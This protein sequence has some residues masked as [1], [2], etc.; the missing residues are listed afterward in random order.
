VRIFDSKFKIIIIIGVGFLCFFTLGMLLAKKTSVER[1]YKVKIDD[2]I[3][4]E[5][6]KLQWPN[7][8]QYVN[9]VMGATSAT[10]ICG[11]SLSKSVIEKLND[12]KNSQAGLTFGVACHELWVLFPENDLKIWKT[13]SYQEKAI[14]AHE[15]FHLAVQMYSKRRARMENAMDYNY[16][17]QLHAAKKYETNEF[18]QKISDISKEKSNNAKTHCDSLFGIRE[19]YNELQIDY[20]R[21]QIGMEWPAEFYMREV[22][23]ADN[24][25]E[26]AAFR[27][28]IGKNSPEFIPYNANI[29]YSAGTEAIKKIEQTVPRKDWQNRYLQGET[30]LNIY[31]ESI[32]CKK[33]DPYA[34]LGTSNGIGNSELI[35]Q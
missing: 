12:K 29:I 4:V 14:A 27:N 8:H 19:K 13:G 10:K 35:T 20:I 31:F 6:S 23:Y 32:G 25:Q 26:Y 5:T 17:M 24:K 28:H 2:R 18:F 22:Y 30:L 9:V 7:K 15:A 1:V 16:V 33:P 11:K 3:W 21:Y 34:P